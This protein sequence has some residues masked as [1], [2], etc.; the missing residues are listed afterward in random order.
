MSHGHM[1]VTVWEWLYVSDCMWVM[2][3]EKA[4]TLCHIITHTLCHIITH[5]L[6]HIITHTLVGDG[7][8]EGICEQVC[9]S[10]YVWAIIFEYSYARLSCSWPRHTCAYIPVCITTCCYSCSSTDNICIQQ[11]ISVFNRQYLYSSTP[12]ITTTFC[13][14]CSP[15][16][17][18]CK[19]QWCTTTTVLWFVFFNRQYSFSSTN[20]ENSVEVQAGAG[21]CEARA[22]MCVLS[23]STYLQGRRPC[24]GNQHARMLS[25]SLR[26]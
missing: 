14:S 24:W 2:V 16:D 18:I 12:C 10:D 11:T 22:K 4:H 13:H 3:H 19:Y 20:T 1:W 23:H 6:C 21:R 25:Q 17:N 7:A 8:W 9:K 5:T 15:T 26:R